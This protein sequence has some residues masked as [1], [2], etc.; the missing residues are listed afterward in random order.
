MENWWAIYL[1]PAVVAILGC[2]LGLY[3]RHS[4][5]AH[6]KARIVKPEIQVSSADQ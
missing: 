4:A 6:R 2:A 5:A 1:A 3:A